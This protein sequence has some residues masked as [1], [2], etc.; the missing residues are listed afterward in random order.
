[1]ARVTEF[2]NCW[3]KL[4]DPRAESSPASVFPCLWG[5][6]VVLNSRIKAP[7]LGLA[8]ASLWSVGKYPRAPNLLT[9]KLP[10][11]ADSAGLGLRVGGPAPELRVS[12]PTGT[13][14][15]PVFLCQV[16]PPR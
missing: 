10:G 2:K 9:Q 4:R 7:K 13:L 16:T 6:V 5:W 3:Q 15:T 11:G 12:V 14:V 8:S 1:M